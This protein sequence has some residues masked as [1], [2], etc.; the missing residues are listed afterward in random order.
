MLHCSLW[1]SGVSMDIQLHL[2]V[3]AKGGRPL[4]SVFTSLACAVIAKTHMHRPWAA[5]DD[6]PTSYVTH[7]IMRLYYYDY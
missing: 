5:P 7:I 2:F 4:A 3:G 6:L 1:L